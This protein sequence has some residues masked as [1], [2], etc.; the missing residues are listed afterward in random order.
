M[1]IAAE[2]YIPLHVEGYCRTFC[3]YSRIFQNRKVCFWKSILRGQEFTVDGIKTEKG[4]ISLA[5]SEKG[6]MPTMKT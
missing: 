4:H 5:I 6:I 2:E 1:Q 3:G